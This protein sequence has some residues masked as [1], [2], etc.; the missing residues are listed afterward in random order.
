MEDRLPFLRS[1][2]RTE[3]SV[4]LRHGQATLSTLFLERPCAPD[5]LPLLVLEKLGTILE[6]ALLDVPFLF[7]QGLRK[8]NMLAVKTT[9]LIKIRKK[10]GGK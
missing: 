8:L 10:E 5:F 1:L 6:S 2:K 3:F 7:Q 4:T 9:E